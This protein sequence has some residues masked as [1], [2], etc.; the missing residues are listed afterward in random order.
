MLSFDVQLFLQI[1]E[2]DIFKETKQYTYKDGAQFVFMDLVLFEFPLC[3][4]LWRVVLPFF[5]PSWKVTIF[6]FSQ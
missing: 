3:D 4:V 1:E 2:A 6:A 5:F